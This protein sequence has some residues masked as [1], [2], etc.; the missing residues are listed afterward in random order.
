MALNSSLL[1]A[2]RTTEPLSTLSNKEIFYFYR[3]IRSGYKPPLLDGKNKIIN[4]SG[5][6]SNITIAKIIASPK[7][8][9]V[10]IFFSYFLNLWHLL[11]VFLPSLY[12]LIINCLVLL[13]F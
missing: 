13:R 2:R 3:L 12:I 9:I 8:L 4:E 11:V 7:L 5:K 10:I 1:V 6:N